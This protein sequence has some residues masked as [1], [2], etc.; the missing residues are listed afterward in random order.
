MAANNKKGNSKANIRQPKSNLSEGTIKNMKLGMLIVLFIFIIF[1]PFI[2]GLYFEEDQLPAEI[3]ILILFNIYWGFK[4]LK[5]DKSFLKT[6]IEYASLGFVVVYFISVALYFIGI[7]VAVFPRMA[8]SEWL[9]YCMYFSIF[10]M[11]TDLI[12]TFK[13]KMAFL[14][15]I[16]ASTA[17]LC[18]IGIDGA[19]SGG[20]YSFDG[21]SSGYIANIFNDILK[22][23]GSDVR[24][25]DLFVNGKIFST[26][27]YSNAF[28]SYLLAVFAVTLGITIVSKRLWVKVL[29]GAM[30]YL[31]FVCFLY[32]GSRGVLVLAPIVALLFIVV[33]PKEKKTEGFIYG[34]ASIISAGLIKMLFTPTGADNKIWLYIAIGLIISAVLTLISKIITDRLGKGSYK[35]FAFIVGIMVV[36]GAVGTIYALNAA[37]PLK[38]S[39][40]EGQ[41]DSFITVTRGAK[42]DP[43]KEYKLEFDVQAAM[44]KEKPNAYS[45]KVANKRLQD[46]VTNDAETVIGMF[47]GKTTKGKE[48]KEFTFRLPE[49]SKIVNVSFMN[50]YE[51]TS[52]EFDNAR[53]IDPSTGKTVKNFVLNYKYL[54]DNAV[55]RLEN[56]SADRS[57][58]ERAIFNKDGIKMIGDRWLLGAGGGSWPSIYFSYQSFMYWST[59]P[60]NYFLQVGVETGVIGLLVLAFLLLSI[61]SMFI[62]GQRKNIGPFEGVLQSC[63]FTAIMGMFLHSILDFDLSL[64]AVSILLWSLIAVF[65][66]LYRHEEDT[67]ALEYKSSVFNIVFLFAEKLKGIKSLNMHPVVGVVV[68]FIILMLP[69]TLYAGISYSKS[70][71]IAMRSGN[72]EKAI[73]EQDKA[74]GMDPSMPQYK[75]DYVRMMLQKKEFTKED[76]E[77]MSKTL[78]K[79]KNLCNNS[80][81]LAA[82]LGSLYISTSKFD[83]GLKYFERATELRPFRPEEWQQEVLAYNTVIDHLFKNKKEQEAVKFLDK[84]LAMDQRAKEVNK[85][86]LTPFIFTGRTQ[87]TI[88][89]IKYIK[90]KIKDQKQIYANKLVFYNMPELD[91]D[92]NGIPDQWKYNDSNIKLVSD[93][94]SMV[95]ENKLKDTA[96]FIDSRQLNMK[97]NQS[98]RIEVELTG[99][100]KPDSIPFRVTGANEQNQ[101]LKSEGN[102]YSAEFTAPQTL[103]N[104]Y[105]VLQ[106]GIKGRYEIKNITVM[107][108]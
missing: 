45:V 12:N 14:W 63:L 95:A 70:A 56:L 91:I 83:E 90:E 25:F 60:H 101:G 15:V 107:E 78:D 27:Q 58:V 4:I 75:L 72:V 100:S 73:T 13:L 52:V 35:V 41:G 26:L 67:K 8:M 65:N 34:F 48:K 105:N 69:I 5:W 82:T 33:L 96:A 99:D 86:N 104:P 77:S 43:G 29:S 74:V 94:G 97:P 71:E 57:A 2:R 55:S 10:F 20:T 80:P 39:H 87:E 16:I 61:V 64:S 84:P 37:L 53:I 1:P 22:S 38:M 18:I 106:L 68:T 93:K 3:I 51:G 44:S 11:L 49:E 30:S 79:V 81:D 7:D 103:S 88:E 98:Y 66:S 62:W 42:L 40:A 21:Q 24:L 19:A 9:K 36:L 23:M 17:G 76:I 46:I 6:P 32:S 89:K 54:P 28:A 31:F 92:E 102:I 59:Q 50:I 85:R 108:K 47:E